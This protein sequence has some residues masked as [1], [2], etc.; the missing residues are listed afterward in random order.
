MVVLPFAKFKSLYM[1]SIF[2]RHERPLLFNDKFSEIHNAVSRRTPHYFHW[3]LAHPM[4][5]SVDVVTT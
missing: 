2:E 4:T 3:K 5:C 1:H